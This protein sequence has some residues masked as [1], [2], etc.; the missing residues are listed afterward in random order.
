MGVAYKALELDTKRAINMGTRMSLKIHD[1]EEESVKPGRHVFIPKVGTEER[2]MD[3]L[4]R[5]VGSNNY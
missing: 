4:K 3:F 1:R 2:I 5:Y